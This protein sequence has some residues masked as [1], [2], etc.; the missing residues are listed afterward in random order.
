MAYLDPAPFAAQHITVTP[1]RPPA[2]EIWASGR[3]ISAL[4]A[5]A[6]LGPESVT[7]RFRALA[8]AHRP[9]AE[10]PARPRPSEAHAAYP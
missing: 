7:A 3:R 8:A 2:T 5:L 9:T 10:T 4:W 1:F 6:T